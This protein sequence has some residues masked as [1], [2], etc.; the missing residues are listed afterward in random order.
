MLLVSHVGVIYIMGPR[1]TKTSKDKQLSYLLDHSQ[2][3]VGEGV[4]RTRVLQRSQHALLP[5]F[6]FHKIVETVDKIASGSVFY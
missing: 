6:M 5:L 2:C 3:S 4:H 1:G